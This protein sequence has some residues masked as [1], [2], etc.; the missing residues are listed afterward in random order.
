MIIDIFVLAM[1]IN[2]HD[3]EENFFY[4]FFSVSL[5]SEPSIGSWEECADQWLV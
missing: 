5:A 1:H 4:T 2:S 3:K